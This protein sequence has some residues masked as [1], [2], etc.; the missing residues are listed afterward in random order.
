MKIELDLTSIGYR[1]ETS[2][3]KG[4]CVKTIKAYK[5]IDPEDYV[6]ALDS[7]VKCKTLISE[8]PDELLVVLTKLQVTVHITPETVSVI[9]RMANGDYDVVWGRS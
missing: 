6:L 8:S 7:A 9:R 2:I 4:W 1:S 5:Y 3:P